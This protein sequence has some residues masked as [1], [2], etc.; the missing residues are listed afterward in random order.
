MYR[1]CKRAFDFICALIGIIGTSPIW[2]F[3]IVA[4]LI[5]DFGPLFYFA[6]RVGQDNKKFKMCK[7]RSMRV[8]SGANEASWRADQARIFRWSTITR[9]L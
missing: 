9:G 3:S 2:V 8:A 6:N 1:I 4:T 7:F 5:S